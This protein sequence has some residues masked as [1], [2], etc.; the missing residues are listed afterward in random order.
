MKLSVVIVSYNVAYFLEQALLSVRR[1]AAALGEPVEVFVVDNNSA[2]NSV[3]MVR[4]R[5][6]EVLLIE[7][8]DNPGFSRANNQA[9]RQAREKPGLSS[10]S[11]S[12][13]S[14]KRSRT[15]TT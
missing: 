4:D 3:V 2:D 8:E 9:L 13:T 15:I 5:F 6:P 1:A 10:F 12:R 14:G 11:M 7:N